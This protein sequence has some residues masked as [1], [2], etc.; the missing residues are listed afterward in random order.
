[1]RFDRSKQSWRA[2]QAIQ[3]IVV[4]WR[5]PWIAASPRSSQWRVPEIATC[6]ISDSIGEKFR[7]YRCLFAFSAAAP[8][9][10]RY[11]P[12]K[13]VFV[14]DVHSVSAESVLRL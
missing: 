12:S 5:G 3:E 9:I 1:M 10:W 2:K 13:T 14:A 11:V 4:L 8:S 6:S 7:G